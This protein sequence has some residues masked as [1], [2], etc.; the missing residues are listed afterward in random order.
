MVETHLNCKA[1]GKHFETKSDLQDHEKVCNA[2][3]GMGG[4]QETG[5]SESQRRSRSRS[6]TSNQSPEVGKARGAGDGGSWRGES[7]V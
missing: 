5:S 6:Q 2:E 1:C 7:D 4:R 3:R